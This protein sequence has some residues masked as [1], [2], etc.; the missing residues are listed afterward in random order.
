MAQSLRNIGGRITRRNCRMRFALLTDTGSFRIQIR[1]NA[2]S[3]STELIAGVK[4]AKPA[5]S[6]FNGYPVE[7]E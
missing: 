6:V 7:P 5:E 2:L 3:G 1:L 4:P